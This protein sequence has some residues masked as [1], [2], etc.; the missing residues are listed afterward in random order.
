MILCFGVSWC[1]CNI[2]CITM[3]N[4]LR[5][6]KNVL[7]EIDLF[8]PQSF[9]SAAVSSCRRH[10]G[11]FGH[12]VIYR[13]WRFT[14]DSVPLTLQKS[15]IQRGMT[16]L[17]KKQNDLQN[18]WQSPCVLCADFFWL[19]IFRQEAGFSCSVIVNLSWLKSKVLAST[20]VFT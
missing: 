11:L 5:M 9:Y 8:V 4:M 10:R 12:I 19:C 1:L 6:W 3:W 18:N 15:I 7:S 16:H 17:G 14:S 20:L 13:T 2:C